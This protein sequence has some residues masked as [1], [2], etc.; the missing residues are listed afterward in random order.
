[1][2]WGTGKYTDLQFF[3][4]LSTLQ[5]NKKLRKKP[6]VLG[7]P[8]LLDSQHPLLNDGH[9]RTRCFCRWEISNPLNRVFSILMPLHFGGAEYY[10]L[11][12][13]ST[14]LIK[15]F[16]DIL[17]SFSILLNARWRAITEQSMKQTLNWEGWRELFPDRINGLSGMLRRPS[18]LRTSSQLW[19]VSFWAVL[20]LLPEQSGKSWWHYTSSP[21]ALH[22]HCVNLVSQW[23]PEWVSGIVWYFHSWGA[24]CFLPSISYWT[25]VVERF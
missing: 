19:E 21:C 18:A 5:W 8:C 22:R 2:S 1:M 12:L 11:R 3:F 13:I 9:L 23:R 14:D 20:L 7:L 10:F 24:G 6:T 16:L 4:L 17:S 25:S 15:V